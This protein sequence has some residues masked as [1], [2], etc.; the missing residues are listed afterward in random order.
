MQLHCTTGDDAGAQQQQLG[1]ADAARVVLRVKQK[2]EGRMDVVGLGSGGAAGSGGAEGAAA[3]GAKKG[4]GSTAAAAAAAGAKAGASG[5]GGAAVAAL[6]ALA[7]VAADLSGA[8]L[9]VEGQVSV[10]GTVAA[11]TNTVGC[12]SGLVTAPGIALMRALIPSRVQPVLLAPALDP[13]RAT[14]D[15]PDVAAPPLPRSPWPTVYHLSQRAMHVP[16]PSL[17]QV[18]ALLAEAQDPAR[19]CRMYPGWSAWM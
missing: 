19:W 10:L 16:A 9:S 8:P 5:G 17:L 7:A 11:G 12:A 14:P 4:K 6:A 13:V 18:R 2:L 3:A 1:N 15:A